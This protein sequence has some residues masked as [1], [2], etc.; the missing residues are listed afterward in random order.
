MA[1]LVCDVC[2]GNLQMDA[3]GKTATCQFCGM[4]YSVERMREKIQEIRG[5]V[6]VEGSVQA[7]QTGTTEDV[8]QWR[9]LMH[10]YLEASDYQNAYDIIGKI[11]QAAPSD[12]ECSKLYP[13]VRDYR[14]LKIVDGKLFEYNGKKSELALPDGIKEIGEDAFAG[15]N[16]IKKLILPDSVQTIAAGAFEKAFIEEIVIS[17]NSKLLCIDAHAFMDSQL[18]SIYIPA[19]LTTLSER[20][21][22][23]CPL[24]KVEFAPNGNLTCIGESAFAHTRITDIVIPDY[25]KEIRYQAFCGCP[26]EKVEFAPNGNLTCI[27]ESAFAHTRITNIVIPNGIKEIGIRAFSDCSI[28]K[29]VSFSNVNGIESIDDEAFCGCSSLDSF[30]ESFPNMKEAGRSILGNPSGSVVQEGPLVKKQKERFGEIWK[31]NGQCPECGCR[32]IK[33]GL[34]GTFTCHNCHSNWIN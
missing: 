32:F 5:T 24:E 28:L 15:N 17:P 33:K 30:P 22:R 29:N 2:G 7:R 21:F 1:M 34:L 18:T 8:E 12:E 31:R 4:Q 14:D 16:G 10:K 3:G 19:S 9:V 26:L 23:G 27:G 11:M 20:A 25:I 13:L 6:K